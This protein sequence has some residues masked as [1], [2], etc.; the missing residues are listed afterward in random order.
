MLVGPQG[1]LL[2]EALPEVEVAHLA[3]VVV[4][5][6]AVEDLLVVAV[7]ALS[8][9]AVVRPEDEEDLS[10]DEEAQ[11]ERLEAVEATKQSCLYWIMGSGMVWRLW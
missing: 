2:D 4:P 5:R 10:A 1:D 8:V 7:E 6:E 3:V 11:E 9:V